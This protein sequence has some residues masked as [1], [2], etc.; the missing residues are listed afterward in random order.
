[1]ATANPP[2]PVANDGVTLY[3]APA[4]VVAERPAAS[5]ERFTLVTNSPLTF[6][7]AVKLVAL[8]PA[9]KAV[10]YILLGP[11]AFTVKALGVMANVTAV[12]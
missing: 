2:V 7:E 8:T 9:V 11:V 3:A 1:M 5:G 6:P 4:A 12:V 10:P